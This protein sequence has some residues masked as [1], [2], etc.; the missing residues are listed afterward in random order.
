MET[1]LKD[2]M[3]DCNNTSAQ[4]FKYIPHEIEYHDVAYKNTQAECCNYYCVCVTIKQEEMT[5]LFNI[6]QLKY[7]TLENEAIFS[8]ISSLISE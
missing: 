6:V 5:V 7:C 4:K 8:L 3:F 2:F 1:G